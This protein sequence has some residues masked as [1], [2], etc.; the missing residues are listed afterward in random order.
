MR[1]RVL[2]A[3]RWTMVSV[4]EVDWKIAP[5]R[6]QF[7]AQG[8]GVGEIAVMRDGQA[9]ARQIGEHRLDVARRGCRRRWN[10]GYGRWRNRP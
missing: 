2:R 4:S 9:A 7:L 6:H 5:W 8:M 10:S 1:G 3:V